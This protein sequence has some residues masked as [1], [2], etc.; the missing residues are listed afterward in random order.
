M[1]AACMGEVVVR[2]AEVVRG[3][4]LL[5]GSDGLVFAKRP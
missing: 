3:C 5:V 1:G 2:L 4:F